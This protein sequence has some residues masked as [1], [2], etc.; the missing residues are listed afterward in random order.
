MRNDGFLF[1]ERRERAPIEDAR[2]RA[3]TLVPVRPWGRRLLM[4]VLL[5]VGLTALLLWRVPW[6]QSVVAKGRV[7]V[8]A[9][10]DRPQTVEAQISGRLVSW[11]VQEGETV[12][13]GQR[14]AVLEDIDS[15]FLD[16]NRI[17]RVQTQLA[18]QR[19]RRVE[20]ER[21][22]AEIEEQIGSLRGSREA[23][24]P[25]AAQRIQQSERRRDAAL[26]S[27]AI[28]EKNLKIAR[29]V[30]RNQAE[31]RIL[32]ARIA[33]DQARQA[34]VSAR[35]DLETEQL[36]RQRIARLFA[37]GLRSRQDDEFAQRD[38]VLRQTRLEQ[39]RNAVANAQRDVT[40]A[41]RSRDQIDLEVQRAQ[42]LVLQARAAADVAQRDIAVA[43]FDRAKV[44]ADTAA[45]INVAQSNAQS[46]R[47]SLASLDDTIAKLEMEL[48]NMRQR[49]GQQEV[50][51]PVNGRVVRI[52]ATVGPGQTVK[53]GDM[54]ALIAPE[55]GDQAV[56]LT[57]RGADAPL[58]SPGRKV[59]LQFN[60]FPAVQISGFPQAAVGTFGGVVATMDRLDDGTGNVRIWV[61]PDVAGIQAGS[62]HPWPSSDLLRP[63]ADTV[64]WVM[65]ETVPLG[66]ELWR[67]FNAFPPN[68]RQDDTLPTPVGGA[69]K[70][71]SEGNKGGKGDLKP[72]IKLPKR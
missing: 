60:G 62:E 13:R 56:E 42:E 28:A 40:I 53:A 30:A 64:A 2:T 68:F 26:R 22:L 36:R 4:V 52:G 49:A 8:Y 21:R 20:E 19:R 5:L 10:M 66:Y 12:R 1:M 38:L 17:L 48:A 23:Q 61:R 9:V 16:P 59:R 69:S 41:E 34:E 54:L 44:T 58:V 65:L 27:V 50:T 57:L 67:Q 6:Q 43:G 37:E 11:D 14:I 29:E 70:E 31:E 33:V 7:G 55:S 3:L 15:K 71:K 47:A 46:A 24:L 32:K 45:G 63:G 25:T 18:A 51:S 39:A 72:D 35:Q